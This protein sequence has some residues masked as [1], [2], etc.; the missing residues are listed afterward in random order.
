MGKEQKPW[1]RKYKEED[2]SNKQGMGGGIGP[3]REEL[4]DLVLLKTCDDDP[5]PKKPI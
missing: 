5:P 3:Y 1:R 4:S 2:K